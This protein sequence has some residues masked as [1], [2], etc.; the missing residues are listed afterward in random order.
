MS[1]HLMIVLVL[2]FI[3]NKETVPIQ[4]EK[5]S[6]KYTITKSVF[7]DGQQAGVPLPI[8]AEIIR[9]YSFDI[10]FQRDIQKGNKLEIMYKVLYNAQ[11]NDKSYGDIEYVNLTFNKNNLEYFIFKT[12]YYFGIFF[13]TLS[14][15]I[16]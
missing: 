8:L 14:I 2:S 13:A 4:L 16:S 9:L 7:E 15:N 12:S 5:V 10:D 3:I 6:K 1:R 11:R